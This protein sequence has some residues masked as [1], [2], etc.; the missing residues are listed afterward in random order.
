MPQFKGTSCRFFLVYISKT[1][2]KKN[3][4]FHKHL[5]KQCLDRLTLS[6]VRT[7]K[8]LA[9]K[10]NLDII[11]FFECKYKVGDHRQRKNTRVRQYHA[12]LNNCQSF[13]RIPCAA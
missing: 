13:F 10:Q 7:L 6:F 3:H 5:S 2:M 4:V 9:L 11:M 8:M 1:K 12:T